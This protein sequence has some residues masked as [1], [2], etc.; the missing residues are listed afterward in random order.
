VIIRNGM[1]RRS[2]THSSQPFRA[3]AH[4]AAPVQAT[5]T[6]PVRVRM[7]T[8]AASGCLR[9]SIAD[10]SSTALAWPHSRPPPFPGLVCPPIAV[11]QARSAGLAAPTQP[12]AMFTLYDRSQAAHSDS[13]PRG[14]HARQQP[15]L[16]HGSNPLAQSRLLFAPTAADSHTRPRFTRSQQLTTTHIPGY[17]PQQPTPTRPRVTRSH[18]RPPDHLPHTRLTHALGS[19]AP[20]AGSHSRPRSPVPSSR[21]PLTYPPACPHESP[22]RSPSPHKVIHSPA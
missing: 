1:Y 22:I 20:A 10:L 6:S 12:P 3:N 16:T 5:A 4:A 8:G 18:S 13:R 21:L 11:C 7:R 19:P 15:T 17:L 14:S 2:S 9:R